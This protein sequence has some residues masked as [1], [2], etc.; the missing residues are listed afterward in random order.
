M[1]ERPGVHDLLR[2][3]GSRKWLQLH[4]RSGEEA[5]AAVEAGI[6]ILSCEADGTLEAVRAA[7][8]SAFISTGMAHGSVASPDAAFERF[9]DLTRSL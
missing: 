3:K 8:P 9:L 5:A 6:V 2:R 4:V 1:A 7:A